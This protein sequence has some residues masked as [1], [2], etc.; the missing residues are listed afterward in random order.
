MQTCICNVK[1]LTASLSL[2]FIAFSIICE[3]LKLQIYH[4]YLQA[5]NSTDNR[6]LGYGENESLAI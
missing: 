1:F 2:S 6:I 3:F 4:F 5:N